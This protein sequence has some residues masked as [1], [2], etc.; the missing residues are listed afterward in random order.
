MSGA[1]P[2]PSDTTAPPEAFFRH[3]MALVESPHVGAGT[4]VWAFAHVLPGAVI[5]RECNLCDGVFIENDV[6][7]GDRVTVKCGV[8]LWDGVRLEDDVFV[9]PNATFTN[10]PFPRSR[11]YPDSFPRTVVR[12]GASIGAN[13]TILP[14]VEIGPGAMVGAGAVVTSDVPAN[15]VVV[16]NP[17]RVVRWVESAAE[18]QNVPPAASRPTVLE[19]PE[20]TLGVD[21]ARPLHLRRIDEMGRGEL[22][23]GEVESE[24]PFVP[25]RFFC[26]TNVPPRAVRGQHAHMSLHEVLVCIR[27]ACTILLDDGQVRQE[28]RLARN[29]VALHIEP[30]VWRELFDFTPDAVLMVLASAPYGTKDYI[31]DYDTFR[32]VVDELAG[33]GPERP[34]TARPEGGP[35]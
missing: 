17:A 32:A 9:G 19:G 11:Q 27:G 18:H 26:V 3:P 14:G 1:L 23:V 10:D 2:E 13:A 22:I 20:V 31:R 24:L 30:L 16:G 15:A 25:E 4:R 6:V 12:R 8:Q 29:E 7:V 21:G 33:R 34:R 28:V 5:G 35:R